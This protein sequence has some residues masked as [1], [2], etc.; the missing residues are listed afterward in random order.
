MNIL[1]TSIIIIMTGTILSAQTL[2]R[3]SNHS[4]PSIQLCVDNAHLTISQMKKYGS[5]LGLS[6]I[7]V[8]EHHGESASV[9]QTFYT[10]K[11]TRLLTTI[12]C[13]ADGSSKTASFVFE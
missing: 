2:I 11:G 7:E 10:E 4:Y 3:Q 5:V 1:T 8:N 9:F 6:Q 13:N 12:V